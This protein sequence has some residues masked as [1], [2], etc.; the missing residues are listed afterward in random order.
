MARPQNGTALLPV[1][2]EGMLS[3][4]VTV[5][6]SIGKVVVDPLGDEHA[7]VVAFQLIAY[8]GEPGTFRF[9]MEDGKTCVVTVDHVE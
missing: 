9:P 3:F 1:D 7:H 5:S 8:H 2:D 6:K 4:D